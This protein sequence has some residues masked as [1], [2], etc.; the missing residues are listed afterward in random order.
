MQQLERNQKGLNGWTIFSLLV[1]ATFSLGFLGYGIY[2]VWKTNSLKGSIN[3]EIAFF[4]KNLY[5]DLK[6]I[7]INGTKIIHITCPVVSTAVPFQQVDAIYSTN[8]TFVSGQNNEQIVFNFQ[9]GIHLPGMDISIT[10]NFAPQ[11][12][13][14]DLIKNF[15]DVDFNS[16][17][18]IDPGGSFSFGE[19]ANIASKYGYPD[20]DSQ[21]F[22]LTSRFRSFNL[23]LIGNFNDG[24]STLIQR[25]SSS[26][27][28][29]GSSL[30]VK[31]SGIDGS[32]QFCSCVKFG[33]AYTEH[34]TPQ[35]TI[36]GGISSAIS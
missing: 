3:N 15:Y 8:Q 1:F 33:S 28:V 36:F 23:F 32:S 27:G 25:C 35:L 13:P 31:V 11:T 34:C 20:Y 6:C 24:A 22:G 18:S 2:A 17:V 14:I 16:D 26:L 29:Q 4:S 10:D 19:T 7:A 5:S 30:Y 12:G 21:G 9:D